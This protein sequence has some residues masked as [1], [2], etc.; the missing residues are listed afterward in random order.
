MGHSNLMIFFFLA[1]FLFYHTSTMPVCS[2]LHADSKVATPPL[3]SK[4]KRK[5][6][7]LVKRVRGVHDL[8]SLGKLWLLFATGGSLES[9]REL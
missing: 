6:F 5:R 1:N 8:G 4:V 9:G 3:R 2:E 7:P